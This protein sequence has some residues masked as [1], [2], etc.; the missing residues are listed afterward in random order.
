[1]LQGDS[2]VIEPY[3]KIDMVGAL[4]HTSHLTNCANQRGKKMGSNRDNLT[5]NVLQFC[6]R[7]GA[8]RQV[9]AWSALPGFPSACHPLSP[10]LSSLPF[11]LLLLLGS[12]H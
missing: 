1:V 9:F 6:G 7:L 2:G 10:P 3:M 8:Y 4:L 12:Q 11:A 5:K